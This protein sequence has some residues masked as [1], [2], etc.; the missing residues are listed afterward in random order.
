MDLRIGKDV[1]GSHH[2]LLQELLERMWKEATITYFRN[3]WKGC[4]R[5]A[6]SPTSGMILTF[7][8]VTQESHKIIHQDNF[9]VGIQ[10]RHLQTISHN[11][12]LGQLA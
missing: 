10:S 3:Y 4:G 1:E 9:P 8:W 7:V 12:C 6:S 2:H 5:K 11:Y